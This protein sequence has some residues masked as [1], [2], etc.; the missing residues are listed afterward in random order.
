IAHGPRAIGTYAERPE[1]ALPGISRL[2]GPLSALMVIEQRAFWPLLFADPAQQPI[3]VTSEFR[4]LSQS[5][6]GLVNFAW[7]SGANAPG[8]RVERGP[9]PADWGVFFR[10]GAVGPPA[11]AAP[12]CT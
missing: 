9:L 2:D 1:L 8:A 10:P 4:P 11:G 7:L 3:E 6:G 5:P 12:A